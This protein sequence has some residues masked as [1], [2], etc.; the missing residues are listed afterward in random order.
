[1][2]L[3]FGALPPEV[4]SG[5]MYS[6]PGAEPMLAAA[7]AWQGLAAQLRSTAASY[8][9]VISALAADWQGPSAAAM[10]AAAAARSSCEYRGMSSRKYPVVAHSGTTATRA[11]FRAQAARWPQMAAVF[12][13]RSWPEC[14]CTTATRR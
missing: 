9:S 10:A 5:R 14:I 6:G 7:A 1:M 11:P 13:F 12:S 3:D 2:A 4:N 8:S